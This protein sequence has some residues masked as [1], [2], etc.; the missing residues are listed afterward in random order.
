M[1]KRKRTKKL[2]AEFWARDAEHRRLLAE[3]VAAI[4]RRLE[5]ERL[6]RGQREQQA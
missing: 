2:S 5:E 4:E 3:Q 6:A 1:K